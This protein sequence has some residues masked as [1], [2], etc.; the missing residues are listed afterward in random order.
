MTRRRR[1]ETG[2]R[3][4]AEGAETAGATTAPRL[5]PLAQ[6]ALLAGPLLSMLDSSIVNVAVAPI[7]S[8][9]NAT[10]TIVQWVSSGYLLALG[11]GLALTSNLA[12]RYGT[13]RVYATGVIAFTAASLLCGLAPTID[14]LIAARVLQGLAGATLV[15]LAMGMLMGSGGASRD[16]SPLAGMLLFLGPAL[17]PSLGGLL[18]GVF[19]WRSIFFINIPLGIV[20]ALT[21]RAV[22]RR[23]AP[24][25]DRG[26]RFDL[27]GIALLAPG[28]FGVLFGLDRGESAGWAHPESWLPIAIGALLLAG[29]V[30]RSIRTPHPALDLRILRD[31]DAAL[32]FVLCAAAS[33]AAWSIIFL[34]PVFLQAVQGHSALATGLA[35]LPQGILT[36][37]GAVFGQ[38]LA[39]RFGVRLVVLGGFVVLVAASLG[40]LA[41]DAHTSLW[42]TSLILAARSAAIGLVVTPLLTVVNRRLT[43]EEQADANTAFNVVQRIGGSL[44]I[45]LIAGVF[46]STSQTAGPVPALHEVAVIVTVIAAVAALGSLFLPRTRAAHPVPT[47]AAGR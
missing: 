14:L 23:L 33:V 16:V 11:T 1:P 19:G 32:S 15:P 39:D 10:L 47:P 42:A 28:L 45:G 22:P 12:R 24:Q 7:A 40:L 34:L 17:G 27:V 13:I 31:R 43:L 8:E 6:Y 26:A 5:S 2:Q 35:M 18:I 36:G 3:P 9:M 4:V 44:G 41:V 38:K 21:M 29:Y 46:T 30:L 37:L 25:G 20:A